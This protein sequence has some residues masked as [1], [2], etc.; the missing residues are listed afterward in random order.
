[1]VIQLIRGTCFHCNRLYMPRATAYLY[2]MQMKALHLGLLRTVDTL[3][4]VLSTFSIQ[5]SSANQETNN[6]EAKFVVIKEK[7]DT[8]LKHAIKGKLDNNF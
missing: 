5:S 3:R 6:F 2:M 1:M 8:V 7:M 4:D